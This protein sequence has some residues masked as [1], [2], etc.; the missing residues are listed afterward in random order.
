M[1]KT[2]RGFIQI[3]FLLLIVFGAL[4][5]T[6][7]GYYAIKHTPQSIQQ[8]TI[9]DEENKTATTSEPSFASKIRQVIPLAPETV[10]QKPQ[11][12][13]W[14]EPQGLRYKPIE[15]PEVQTTTN[16]KESELEG[17][18]FIK[19]EHIE[20]LGADI[21]DLSSLLENIRY[22]KG[23]WISLAEAHAETRYQSLNTLGAN[24]TF[25][26]EISQFAIER[27]EYYR[28]DKENV[29]TVYTQ[30]YKPLEEAISFQLG[31]TRAINDEV[32][33]K[34]PTGEL[35]QKTRDFLLENK[36]Q[37]D[38]FLDVA[39][40]ANAMAQDLEETKSDYFKQDLRNIDTLLS[41]RELVISTNQKLLE[42]EREARART[43][44]R[45]EIH[46][47]ATTQYSGGI[48]NRTS[49]TSIRCE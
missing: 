48:V 44:P 23:R 20:R 3:P 6:G 19:D 31:N 15:P 30:L 40:K 18:A 47:W 35:Q 11:G 13:T 25:F 27:A 14:D 34:I 8:R 36:N 38:S 28:Q 9:V 10:Q 46:C 21:K 43:L 4:V 32:F 45:T 37:I 24:S 49:Q 26:P 42:I 12:I 22:D 29:R 39:M 5:T 7:G 17:Y 16:E 2:T 33:K 41:M 1:Q